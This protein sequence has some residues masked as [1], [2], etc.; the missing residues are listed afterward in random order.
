MKHG[1]SVIVKVDRENLK[2]T[3]IIRST[4]ISMNHSS[5]H[6]SRR[7]SKEMISEFNSEKKT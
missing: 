1:H 5:T 3:D 7:I 6:K 2:I 4:Q